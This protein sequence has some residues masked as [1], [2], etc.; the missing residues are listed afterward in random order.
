MQNKNSFIGI[1]IIIVIMFPFIAKSQ[2]NIDIVKEYYKSGAIKSIVAYKD[3][4]KFGISIDYFKSGNFRI[5]CVY[6]EGKL[7]GPFKIYYDNAQL[8]R[9]GYFQN[10]RPFGQHIFYEIDGK[11]TLKSNYNEKGESDGTWEYYYD[12]ILDKQLLYKKGSVDTIII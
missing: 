4:L 2:L 11:I 3:S 8:Q 10:D 9:E 6:I 7:N 12:G 5:E 1:I